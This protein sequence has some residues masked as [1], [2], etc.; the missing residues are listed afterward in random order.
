MTTTPPP[1][2]RTNARQE[3]GPDLTALVVTHRAIRLDLRRLTA[4]LSGIATRGVPVSRADAICR[5]TAALLIG[6]RAHLDDEDRIV[7]PVIAAAAGAAVDLTPLTDDHEAIRV[8]ASQVSRAVAAVRADPG[9]LAELHAPIGELRDMLDEHI[10]DEEAQIFPATRRYL[11]ADAY[12]WCEKQLGR[13]SS[14]FRRRFAAPWLARYARPG[15]Q[16]RLLASGG[17]PARVVLAAAR[18]GYVRLER[19][20][21]GATS[22]DDNPQEKRKTDAVLPRYRPDARDRAASAACADAERDQGDV[23]G[24]SR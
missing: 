21:F 13:T 24:S 12:R 20:A 3:P 19:R 7:W 10:E 1:A 15:E 17:W 22:A 18:P 4:C 8:A 23:R 16:S 11:P 9:A 5:Y 6:I 14:P 2:A